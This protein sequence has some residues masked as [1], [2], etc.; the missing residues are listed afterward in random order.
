VCIRRQRLEG[1]CA[2]S[3]TREDHSV[4]LRLMSPRSVRAALGTDATQA[5]RASLLV[6]SHSTLERLLSTSTTTLLPIH[7]V[8]ILVR[9]FDTFAL[10]VEGLRDTHHASGH[11]VPRGNVALRSNTRVAH[12]QRQHGFPPHQVHRTGFFDFLWHPGE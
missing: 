9:S 2:H 10:R 8:T 1:A 4:L 5:S 3:L 11:Q 6:A 12:Q 7:A